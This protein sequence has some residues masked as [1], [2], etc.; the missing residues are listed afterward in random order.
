MATGIRAGPTR[1]AVLGSAAVAGA[2]ALPFVARARAA[3]DAAPNGAMTLAWHTNIAPRWLDPQ[4]HDGGATPDNFLNIVHDALIKN[5][6]EK[7]Y[8]HLAL[9]DE[10][11]FAE[12]AR[13][14]TFRLRPG[15]RFHNGEPVTPADV[16][17]SYEHYRGAWAKVLQGNTEAVE[18][19]G[20]RTVQ[21]RFKQPFLDFPRLMGTANVS[22][23]AWVVPAKYYE[24]VGSDGFV[25]KPIGAGPYRLVSQEP[26]T[27]LDFAAFEGYYRPVRTR[28]FTI[29]SVP[30]PATRVAMLER[31]E[32]DIV[33]NVPGELV[34]RVKSNP[35]IMLA[36]V[37]SG[38]FW[39]EFPGFQDPKNP[40]H[41]K[42]VREAVSLALDRDAI[43]RAECAGLGRVDGNWINDDVEYALPWPKWPRDVAKAKALM[44]EAGFPNGFAIDW[45]T[46]APPY[47]S[48][49]ERV[50]A[51]LAAIGIRGRLQVL[52][53]AVFTKRRQ[54]GLKEW[55][56][57]NVVLAGARIG[58]TWA[59][60]YE[61]DFKC[62]GLLSADAFCVKELDDKFAQYLHSDRPSERQALAEDI[63]KAILENYYFVPVF[64][65]AFMNAIGPR[66]VAARWQDVFPTVTTGY[67][68]PWE[69]IAVKS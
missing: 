19:V 12:D 46:P 57:V 49:G 13:S 3:G 8:D 50:L 37:V 62:G 69:D 31:G 30:D 17:W 66:I 42:R 29:I 4:Q 40:F 26:G 7:L 45:L 36:P 32:A 25:Q 22:G 48:R 39:L 55:P 67:A 61:A 51:Q 41:D 60:W 16:K 47:Y 11:E 5:F 21:F 58:A 44:A 35:N 14:A 27:R 2:L 56:G 38:N 63:Q 68:Y 59:N 33:Y 15:T 6:R 65:H 54:G 20:E 28:K 18:T 53:R 34:A 23:A 52:E 9:A 1:R 24:E 64:R 43:N 10:F